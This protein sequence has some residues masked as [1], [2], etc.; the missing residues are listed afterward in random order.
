MTTCDRCNA[1]IDPSSFD[2]YDYCANCLKNLC[3]QCMANGCCGHIPAESGM[4]ADHDA[5][6]G[7]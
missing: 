7:A 2:L 5:Q 3:P 6:Q 1:T 4:K